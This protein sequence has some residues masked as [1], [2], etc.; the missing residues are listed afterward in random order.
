MNKIFLFLRRQRLPFVLA[1]VAC[2]AIA[3]QD[4]DLLLA[5]KK[6]PVTVKFF[7]SWCGSCKD[8]LESLRGKSRNS[9]IIMLSAFDDETSS[10]AALNHFGV[11]QACFNGDAIARKLGVRHLP[12]TF[13]SNNGQLLPKD[14]K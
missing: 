8:D 10:V 14:A 11:D 5:A 9:N 2:T 1:V 13:I 6:N 3:Q 12:R 7:A 4:F